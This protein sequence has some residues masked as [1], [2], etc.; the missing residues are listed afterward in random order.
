MY[1]ISIPRDETGLLSVLLLSHHKVRFSKIQKD[2]FFRDRQLFFSIFLMAYK[3]NTTKWAEQW[4]IQLL[5]PQ[6]AHSSTTTTILSIKRKKWSHNTM[7]LTFWGKKMNLSISNMFLPLKN[8]VISG[9]LSSLFFRAHSYGVAT[10]LS[11]NS[12]QLSKEIQKT[13]VIWRSCGV[14]FISLRKINFAQ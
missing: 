12:H 6:R 10:T 3:I 9:F 5:K 13:Y 14:V 11:C 8:S 4:C 7:F 2:T 1:L